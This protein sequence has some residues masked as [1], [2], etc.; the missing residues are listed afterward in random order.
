MAEYE[1]RWNQ[2]TSGDWI[3][4]D[5]LMWV[6]STWNGMPPETGLPAVSISKRV[7]GPCGDQS[8]LLRG[9]DGYGQIRYTCLRSPGHTFPHRDAQQKGEETVSWWADKPTS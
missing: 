7:K 9:P 3:S 1:Y 4:F 2:G 6:M 8:P 5:D